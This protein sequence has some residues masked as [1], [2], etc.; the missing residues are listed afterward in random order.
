MTKVGSVLVVGGGISGMH[1]SLELADSGFKVYL[2]EKLTSIGGIMSQLDKC[3]IENMEKLTA[4]G[5]IMN[6]LISIERHPHVSILSYSEV[7]KVEG[8]AGNFK[9]TIKKNPRFIDLSKCTGCGICSL[10]CP[11]EIPNE[12]D[13]E[14]RTKSCISMRY[15]HPLLSTFSI[16]KEFCLGCGFCAKSCEVKAIDFNQREEIIEINVGSI[17]LALGAET[18]NP[19]LK[20]VYG[21]R[22]FPNIITSVEF[23]RILSPS[24]PFD[25]HILRPYDGK[26]AKKIAWL[27]CIGSRDISIGHNYCSSVCCMYAIKEALLAKEYNPDIQCYIFNMDIRASGKG[28]EKYFTNAGKMGIKFSKTRVTTIK[29]KGEKLEIRYQDANQNIIDEEFDLV[30]L[31]VGFA[32]SDQY[33]EL[34]QVFGIKLNDYNFCDTTVLEP[35]KTSKEGIFVCGTFKSPKDIP[36]T[37]AEAS[38]AASSA[39]TLL[40]SERNTLI[41]PEEHPI[42]INVSELKPRIGVFICHCGINI[43]SFVNIKEIVAFTKTLPNVICAEDNLI[44]CSQ[45][46]QNRIK[47]IIKE[48]NLNRLVIAACTP[49]TH[50]PLFQNTIREAGLNFYLLSMANIRE[51]VSWVHQLDPQSAIEKAKDL[52]AMAVAKAGLQ[53]PLYNYKVKIVQAGIIIGGGIAGMTAALELANQG[54]KAYLLEKSSELG[55]IAN[56]IK[57][58]ASGEDLASHLEMLKNQIN[59]NEKIEVFLNT[60]IN[61]IGGSLGQFSATVTSNGHIEQI[62]AGTIIIATGGKEYTPIEYN[63][64][65]DDRVLTQI[66]LEERIFNKNLENIKNVVMIQCIGTKCE[67][68]NYCSKICCFEAQKNAI[69]AKNLNPEIDIYILCRETRTCGFREEYYR[70]VRE[71]GVKFIRFTLDN[72]PILNYENNNIIISVFDNIFQKIVKIKTDLL[73]LSAGILPNV[74]ENL[75]NQLRLPLDESQFFLETHTK[76]RPLDSPEDGIFICGFA[77][78]PKFIDETIIQAKGAVSRAC[79][80][81][82]KEEIELEGIKP[83]INPNICIGCGICTEVCPFNALSIV[84]RGEKKISAIDPIKCHGCGVCASFCPRGASE[85]VHFTDSEIM[86]QIESIT[87]KP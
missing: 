38:A 12:Y 11:I 61:E 64:G 56:K 32:C 84:N 39:S 71:L 25:G 49:R 21:Y 15:S 50:E 62:K 72:Q 67:E 87:M 27:Q 3:C 20:K 63:Y 35:V 52:V 86:S 2:V 54:F 58:L 37:V 22:K 82:S 8:T 13:A 31:S 5:G 55:G 40:S 6:Y 18:F 10:S 79:S 80:Y 60:E 53:E 57:F 24:G 33:K 41:T 17:I 16:N 66:E 45:D 42:E 77:H 46:G 30:V 78:S 74:D 70:K 9:V 48:K 36:A 44:A 81:L 47:E 75:I 65:K 19:T 68:R 26:P 51:H 76:L 7:V 1:A 73:I 14:L 69:A 28:F 29:Q 34:S 59:S 43:G 83:R 4:I 23:E 85:L